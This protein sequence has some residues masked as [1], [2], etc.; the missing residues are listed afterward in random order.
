VPTFGAILLNAELDKCLMVK[1]WK[2]GASW[3]FPKG[4]VRLPPPCLCACGSQCLCT[5]VQVNKEELDAP[6][7]AREVRHA[8]PASP[9]APPHGAAGV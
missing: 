1:G 9:L 8:L 7:A 3:G 2:S 6:C 5:T 4:K